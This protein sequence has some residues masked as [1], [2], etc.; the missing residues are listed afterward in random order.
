MQ[1]VSF[2]GMS[3]VCFEFIVVISNITKRWYYPDCYDQWFP[4]EEVDG[5]DPESEQPR[6]GIAWKVVRKEKKPS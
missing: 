4:T 5:P 1:N 6:Q 3:F 2:T